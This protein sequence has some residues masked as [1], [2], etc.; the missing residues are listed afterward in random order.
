MA[1]LSLSYRS[2]SCSIPDLSSVEE[3]DGFRRTFRSR[4]S[5]SSASMAT[6]SLFRVACSIRIYIY[7]HERIISCVIESITISLATALNLLWL[8]MY[9]I[10]LL[11]DRMIFQLVTNILTADTV[12]GNQSPYTGEVYIQKELERYVWHTRHVIWYILERCMRG[13]RGTPGMRHV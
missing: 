5:D 3:D 12:T 11:F 13:M 9:H 2:V 6:I 10:K 8:I 4:S 1:T 7:I